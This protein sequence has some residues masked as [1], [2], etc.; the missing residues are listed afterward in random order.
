MYK[1]KEFFLLWGQV[2]AL[3]LHCASS[4]SVQHRAMAGEEPEL[5]GFARMVGS[6]V[7]GLNLGWMRFGLTFDLTKAHVSKKLLM[8]KCFCFEIAKF[9][10]DS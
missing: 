4:I 3:L 9:T 7:G 6:G 8:R 10:N 5:R 1:P 2:A